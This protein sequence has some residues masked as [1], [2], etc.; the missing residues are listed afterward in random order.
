MT[1]NPPLVDRA[2]QE[3]EKVISELV[4]TSILRRERQRT[5]ITTH[6]PAAAQEKKVKI[7]SNVPIVQGYA[8]HDTNVYAATATDNSTGYQNADPAAKHQQQSDSTPLVVD[9]E[10]LQQLRQHPIKQFQDV[11]WAVLFI[12]H[13]AVMMVVIGL[14]IQQGSSND[15]NGY[16]GGASSING[17]ILFLTS[18]T[19]LTAVALSAAALGFMM[20]NSE[21]LVQT[22]LVFSVAT[23][24]AIAIVGFL[25]GSILMGCLGLFS[26]AVGICYAKIV[27][28]R[29]PFAASNLK[30]ALTAVQANMGLTVVSFGLTA[31]AFGWTI[32][33]FTGA[34][35]ALASSNSPILFV[36]VRE[37]KEGRGGVSNTLVAGH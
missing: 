7:M 24:L 13:L 15:Q 23:S 1:R 16:G 34:G 18:V 29:I 35:N 17:S 25:T 33:W 32:L 36:L 10:D 3:R 11:I 6:H 20:K 4:L 30:T 26:F 8:I 9:P 14:G 12:A 28:T 27:W 37:W 22:A 19:G 21:V 5:H 31:L 2:R